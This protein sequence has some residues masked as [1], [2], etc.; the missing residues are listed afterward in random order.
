MCAGSNI[1]IVGAASSGKTA[2]SL[3]ILKKMKET[4]AVSVFASLDMARS[5]LYEKLL[6]SVTNGERSREE[7]YQDYISGNGRK[8]DD[9]VKEQFPNTFIYS[10]SAPNVEDLKNYLLK[11]QDHTGKPVRLLMIDYFERLGSE[12]SDDTAASKDV[13]AGIQDLIADFPELTP[14]TLYQPNKFSMGGG[15][16][17]PILNYTAI[18]G[19]SFIIQ[20]ARQILSLWRPFFTPEYKDYDKFMEMAILKN[21]LGELDKFCY[22]WQGRTGKISMMDS[23]NELEYE[24]YMAEKNRAEANNKEEF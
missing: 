10:K 13:A 1:A 8:Y 7:I 5:R 22:N 18:K 14:I 16:D 21:D 3:N 11:V 6:Y 15:P 12:K 17:K 20:S 23:E 24:E 19:S 2:L 9:A 4:N